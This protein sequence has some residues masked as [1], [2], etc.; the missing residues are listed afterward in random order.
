MRGVESS[1]MLCSARELGLSDDASGLAGARCRIAPVGADVREALDL[2][3]TLLTLK[4]TPNRGDC[5]SLLGIARE[6]AAITG[7]T[8]HAGA[9][10]DVAARRSPTIARGAR[11]KTPQACARF[12]GRVIRGVDARA[13]TPEWMVRRLE[14]SGIAPDLARWSTSPTT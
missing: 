2:D 6:V 11:S 10:A 1:G 4:L 13:P 12:C 8:R 9:A 3:D 5:L 7:A 14:R